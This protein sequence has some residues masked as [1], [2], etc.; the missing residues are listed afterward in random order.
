MRIIKSIILIVL[1]VIL[2]SCRTR[3][4]EFIDGMS[5]Q[6]KEEFYHL[7]KEEF[8]FNAIV[9]TTAIYIL[10][11]EAS[12]NLTYYSLLRFSNK[13][14]CYWIPSSINSFNTF[15]YNSF[16]KG[17]LCRY[18]IDEN[19]ILKLEIYAYGYKFFVFRYGRF[20]EDRLKFRWERKR[21]FLSMKTALNYGDDIIYF[22]KEANITTRLVFPK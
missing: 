19:N 21:P 9:D 4:P 7:S 14:V 22:K 3:L 12:P 6:P 18:K 5:Q 1:L 16:R 20:D 11:R 2:Y 17:Q 10:E 13:G 15:D 8:A